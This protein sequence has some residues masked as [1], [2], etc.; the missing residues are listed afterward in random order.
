MATMKD[1]GIFLSL[2]ESK[3]VLAN[4]FS[5]FVMGNEETECNKFVGTFVLNEKQEKYSYFHS[6]KWYWLEENNFEYDM[7]NDF[8]MVLF[9][10]P[11]PK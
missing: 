11:H 8:T 10:N 1:Y 4:E 5:S 6:V 9:N 2:E 7:I 3:D